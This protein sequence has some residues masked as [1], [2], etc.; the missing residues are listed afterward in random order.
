MPINQLQIPGYTQPT[1][2][3]FSGFAQLTKMYE[4][5]QNK[6]T[7][8]NLGKGLADGSLDYKQAAGM[9]AKAGKLDVAMSLIKMGE[10]KQQQGDFTK[11]FGQL[12]GGGSSQPSP[13]PRAASS[14][15]N[16][17]QPQTVD[18][19]QVNSIDAMADLKPQT[20]A[21]LPIAQGAVSGIESGGRYDATGPMISGGPMAGQR[22]IGKYQVMESNVGP[23]TKEV[24][25]R[26]MTPQE[27]AASPDAQDAVFNGKFGGYMEKYGSGGAARAWHAGEGGMNNP[28]AGDQLGTST[29]AY[30]NRV[31]NTVD[32]GALPPNA[33]PAGP[34]QQQPQGDP[35]PRTN[36]VQNN[37]PALMYIM[38][39]PGA[40]SGQKE[41]AKV[42]LTEAIKTPDSLKAY[43]FYQR[44][45]TSQGRRPLSFLDYT[46]KEKQAGATAITT[47]MRGE[48]TYSQTMGKEM[49]GMNIEIPKAAIAARGQMATMDRLGQLLN[50]PSVYQGSGGE[51]FAELKR[52]GKAIGVDTGDLGPTEAVR[53]ISNQFALEM[54]NPA[55]GAGMPG[56]M[57]DKD[58]EF[59]Q[60]IVPGLQN[61]PN[62]NA[63][64]IDYK[65]RLAQRSID[66]EAQRRAYVK[67]HGKLD[68]GFFGHLSDWSD[69]NPVF[70]EA[71]KAQTPGAQP[72]APQQQPQATPQLQ[73]GMTATNP[74]TGQ[75]IIFDG[76]QWAPA[77]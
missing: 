12:L 23:W 42:A 36:P 55:G 66:V 41:A 44:Q 8:A 37:I 3:D 53:A 26:A 15:I 32:G 28:A 62:G 22:G 59:L 54:R 63:L 52:M 45:E 71:A 4:D 31:A 30:G 57:S 73:K 33:R 58:R 74:N 10:E 25:G 2:I 48:N 16:L 35:T 1:P 19:N 38:A 5:A 21:K 65:R 61:N 50:D 24:L 43:D 64:L 77:Q 39:H 60:Q 18:P 67:A 27:F 75:K 7:L 72:Q 13:A 11:N 69:A 49:A 34:A 47:D 14:L 29:A 76:V 56:A 40:S 9:A 51:K 20:Q 17:G 70:P 46:I 68:E 6:Q